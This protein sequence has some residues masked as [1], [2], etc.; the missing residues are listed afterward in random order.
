MSGIYIVLYSLY[1]TC[2]Y[3]NTS[4]TVH[5]KFMWLSEWGMRFCEEFL[6]HQQNVYVQWFMHRKEN[7]ILHE[8]IQCNKLDCRSE[9]RCCTGIGVSWLIHT[10]RNTLSW[11]LLLYILAFTFC[12]MVQ[13][14]SEHARSYSQCHHEDASF[15]ISNTMMLLYPQLQ[16]YINTVDIS[17]IK[18]VKEE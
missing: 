4:N 16:K 14:M 10:L 6:I 5:T 1:K 13:N 17:N 15:Y 18:K 3:G 2:K 9:Y 8:F 7:P 11:L 12:W